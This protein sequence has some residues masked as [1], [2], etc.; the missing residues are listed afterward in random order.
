M[1]MGRYTSAALL[2]AAT[3]QDGGAVAEEIAAPCPRDDA[4]VDALCD[5]LTAVPDREYGLAEIATHAV[6]LAASAPGGERRLPAAPI[7]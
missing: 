5:R 6:P 2:Q 7:A 4:R 3:V 1:E